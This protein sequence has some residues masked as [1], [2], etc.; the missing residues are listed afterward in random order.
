MRVASVLALA[1][2]A[3]L[4]PGCHRGASPSS[5]D[6]G[7]GPGVTAAPSASTTVDTMTHASALSGE[8]AAA[9]VVLAGGEVDGNALRTRNRAR[10]AADRGPVVV[11]QSKDA[12][13]ALDLGR[14]LCEAVVPKVAPATPILLKPNIGG[15]DWFKDPA[16]NGG[17]DGLRGRITD[18]EFVRGV[19]R[20]LRARGHEHVTI[21]EGWGAHHKDWEKL[22]DVSG[23][24]R[25]AREEHV[26]LVAMDDDGV[27]DVQGDQPG[28]PLGVRGME[29]TRVP[30]LL[31]PK[32]LADTLA[33]GMFISLPKIKAHRFGVF[34][35]SIK[36]MQGTVMLSDKAPAF[37][38]KWR[39]H[40]ELNP[41]LE[42]Q[43]KGT[44]DRESYVAALEIF[45]ERIADVLEI[46]APDVVLA[47]GAPAEEGDGFEKLWPS[48]ESFAVGGTNPILVDRVGAQLLGLWN[49]ADLARELGGHA[50]SPL[51][52]AAAKKLGVDITAPAV[53]GDGAG[54]LATKRPV[55]LIGM[56]GFAIHSDAAAPALTPSPSPAPAPA[57]APT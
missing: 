28:K 41:W 31:M 21:A 48:A 42:A 44:A 36:G 30:T 33:H 43:R 38:N 20:C 55:H 54:L 51:L 56:A 53:T 5:L 22:V 6:G 46:E 12:H 11:L 10:L 1:L 34:S 37:R 15:F 3:S 29:K 49:N 25:M 47:E 16:K 45:S 27:F 7:A 35:I 40:R 50:T 14:R 17:D 9:P 19:V 18:P 2:A 52:E 32:I 57:P 26:P 4:L 13:P 39:M 23:Y 8:D 24:A